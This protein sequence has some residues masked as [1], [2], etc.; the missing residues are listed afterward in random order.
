[1]AQKTRP[2]GKQRLPRGEALKRL[3]HK[4]VT[5]AYRGPRGNQD[6]DRDALALSVGASERLLTH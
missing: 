6:V 2:D 3:A 4:Q 5:P 1:M